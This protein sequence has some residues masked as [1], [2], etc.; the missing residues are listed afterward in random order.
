MALHVKNG[1]VWVPAK[2]VWVRD[3]SVWKEVA[4]VWV[5]DAGV[6]KLT[7][8]NII[9]VTINSSVANF[10]LASAIGNPSMA[11]NVNVLVPSGVNVVSNSIGQPAFTTG[12]LPAG[13]VV[14]LTVQSGAAIV[15]RGGRG[16]SYYVGGADYT[17]AS[18]APSGRRYAAQN[19]GDAIEAKCQMTIN[20][21][22]TIGGGGGGSAPGGIAECLNSGSNYQLSWTPRSTGL[23]AFAGGQDW[24]GDFYSYFNGAGDMPIA[25]SGEAGLAWTTTD[26]TQIR[27]IWRYQGAS[28]AGGSDPHDLNGSY[29]VMINTRDKNGTV[30]GTYAGTL[31]VFGWQSSILNPVPDYLPQG[32]LDAQ[33]PAGTISLATAGAFHPSDS[34]RKYGVPLNGR[35]LAI[36][37]A[38]A[39]GGLGQDGVCYID[40]NNL[41]PS[42]TTV[43]P[44]F[45][46]RRTIPAGRAGRA[47]VR[48]GNTVTVNGNAVLGAIV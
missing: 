19:G 33:T 44:S 9:N 3:A 2:K 8:Q 4:K 1:G 27:E 26:L 37:A 39:G 40:G 6:W 17:I 22:G 35:G 36:L 32:G 38:P 5:R 13:S 21:S 42:D 25:Y 18:G 34:S 30:T 43:V 16:A 7:Y 15:G 28:G 10:N 45:A 14:N 23:T 31:R 41:L 20:N 29:S 47:I 24:T 46:S 11:V 12:N 48:N